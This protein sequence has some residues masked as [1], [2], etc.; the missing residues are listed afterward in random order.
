MK[1]QASEVQS[2]CPKC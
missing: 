2:Q 1:T